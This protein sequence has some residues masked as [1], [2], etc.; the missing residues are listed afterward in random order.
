VYALIKGTTTLPAAIVAARGMSVITDEGALEE[1]ARKLVSENPRQAGGYR[2]GKANLLGFFVGLM[3]KQTGGSADPATVNLVL[4]RA[5]EG[6]ST[7]RSGTVSAPGP[8]ASGSSSG[9]RPAD[10]VDRVA[11]T[12]SRPEPPATQSRPSAP[13]TRVGLG[14]S[15]QQQTE[16]PMAQSVA[17]PP[18]STPVPSPREHTTLTSALGLS[19]VSIPTPPLGMPGNLVPYEAFARL[20]LRVGKIISAVRVPRK[21]KLLAVAVDVGD[22]T[23]QRRLIS[24]LALSYAPEELVGRRVIVA[25]NVEP[26]DFGGGLI[27]H[28]IIL[29]AGP[30][31]GLAL[32]TLS[33]DL[34]PGTRVK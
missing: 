9:V 1:L 8:A 25:C 16:S 5:L 18:Q 11:E 28:G 2:A 19:A 23:G 34:P 10:V 13:E 30:L 29:A 22:D 27:S 20:D 7:L 24:N 14:P 32:A 3:M 33:E 26:R 6:R 21:E 17:P 12:Q 15:P 4:K 31:E